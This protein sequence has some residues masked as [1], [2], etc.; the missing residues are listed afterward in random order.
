MSNTG[1]QIKLRKAY[2]VRVATAN[3]LSEMAMNSS[4]ESVH[5]DFTEFFEVL[6]ETEPAND[7][8]FRERAVAMLLFTRMINKHFSDINWKDIAEEAKHMFDN[9]EKEFKKLGL[10][11]PRLNAVDHE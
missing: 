1:K 4:H 9:S 8:D 6:M 3:F 7:P 10:N 5:N 11:Y 2:R